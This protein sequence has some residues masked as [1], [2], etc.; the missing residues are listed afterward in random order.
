ME[1]RAPEVG[2]PERLPGGDAE[3][4]LDRRAHVQRLRVGNPGDAGHEGEVVEEGYGA[5]VETGW[6]DPRG[7]ADGTSVPGG[8]SLAARA[9]RQAREGESSPPIVC[10]AH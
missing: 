10:R 7:A 6:G 9:M 2:L 1:P 5:A 4:T 3:Q 8:P